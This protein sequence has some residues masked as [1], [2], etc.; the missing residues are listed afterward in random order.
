MTCRYLLAWLVVTSMVAGCRPQDTWPTRAADLAALGNPRLMF[1]PPDASHLFLTF[2][3]TADVWHLRE[4]DARPHSTREIRVTVN[5]TVVLILRSD[6]AVE[7]S[8][9]AM[10]VSSSIK[11]AEPSVAWF[12]PA[13]PGTYP[14]IVSS[15]LGRTEGQLTIV[16]AD[17]RRP[18]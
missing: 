10:R 6:V 1:L 3:S 12:L 16:A 17:G 8:I 15:A 11:V 4:G 18:K 5:Q 13:T 2:S 7:F 9:P 14:I